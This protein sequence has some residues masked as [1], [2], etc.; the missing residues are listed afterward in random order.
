MERKLEEG[1]VLTFFLQRET[2]RKR[3]GEKGG[4]RDAKYP[5]AGEHKW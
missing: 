4:K 5:Y 2:G 3:R 1:V